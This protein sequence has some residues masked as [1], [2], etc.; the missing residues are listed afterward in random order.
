MRYRVWDELGDGVYRRRYTSFDLN[1][2]L[3]VGTDA[4]LLID[5]RASEREAAVLAT[6]VAKATRV[7]VRHVVNTHAH[8]DHCFGNAVFSDTDIWAHDGCARQLREHGEIRRHAALSWVDDALVPDLAV[9]RLV[10]PSHLVSRRVQL[11]VGERSVVL[12]HLGRGHTDHDLVVRVPDTGVIFAGDLVE[13]SAPPNFED[14]WPLEWPDTLGRLLHH[15]GGPVV[16]GHG[17]VVDGTFVT[18]QREEL[19][20]LAQLLRDVNDNRISEA[21]ALATSPFPEVA[22]RTALLRST[23][24]SIGR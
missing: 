6:E 20:A 1:V 5:T 2:G 9:A 7:P 23:G 15:V 13:E 17:D 22:T 8:F 11:T 3:V 4:A 18:R 10:P 14:A 19:A 24:R 12:E 16:P 21:Q